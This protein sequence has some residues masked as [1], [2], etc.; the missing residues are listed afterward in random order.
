MK[1]MPAVE[2]MQGGKKGK[3]GKGPQAPRRT[4]RRHGRH[5]HGRPQEAPGHAGRV[6]VRPRRIDQARGSAKGS[7]LA[8]TQRKGGAYGVGDT[9]RTARRISPS[10][11]RYGTK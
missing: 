11:I 3:K 8:H 9:A 2:E 10:M 5:E 4:P 1:M 6:A 7:L